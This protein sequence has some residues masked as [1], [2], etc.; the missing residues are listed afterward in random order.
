MFSSDIKAR[1]IL[2]DTTALDA[3]GV[4]TSQTPASAGNLT[5][6]GAQASGG[7]ASFTAARQITIAS[8][9]NIS[10]RTFT[11]TGTDAAGNAQ[12][13]TITGPN[14]ATVTTTGYFKTITQIAISGAAAGAL[15]VGMNG[16]AADVIF[17]G[18]MRLRGAHMLFSGT[19]GVLTFKEGSATGTT[20]L[21]MGA[22]AAANVTESLYVPEDGILFVDG[23]YLLY[24]VE[25]V[26]SITIFYA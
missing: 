16:N 1:Y 15:T 25:A 4:C 14:N 13:E 21:Q 17:A 7:V 26:V 20:N 2:A 3:D 10:N 9:S 24:P 6:N 11:I 8:S 18:R 5:I 19:G 12:V 23:G 22:A